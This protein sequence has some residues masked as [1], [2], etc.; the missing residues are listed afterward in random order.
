MRN[1]LIAL[2]LVLLLPT[3]LPGAETLA[4]GSGTQPVVA[5]VVESSIGRTVLEYELSSVTKD[6]VEIDGET[7]YA[8]GLGEESTLLEAGLPESFKVL[9]KELL[10]LGL[11]VQLF[12]DSEA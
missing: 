9:L 4:V 8:I 5:R 7:Y 10:S 6:A 2:C 1:A 12:E 11:E 3:V